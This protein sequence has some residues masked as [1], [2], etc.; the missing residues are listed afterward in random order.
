MTET[1]TNAASPPTG[2][3]TTWSKTLIMSLLAAVA[4]GVV[5]L[6]FLWPVATSS[7]KDLPVGIVGPQI[8]V[9]QVEQN[10]DTNAPGVFDTSTY[11]TR[12]EAI[13]AIRTRDIDGAIV[14][15]RAPE[16]LIASAAGPAV[17]SILKG[18]AGSMQQQMSAQSARPG[19]NPVTTTVT[20]TDVVPLAGDDPNGSGLSA[21]GFPLVLAGLLGGILISLLVAGVTRR[22]VALVV[23]AILGGVSVTLVT[24]TWFG[25]LPG[26]FFL[27]C[28]GISLAVLGT[29]SFVVGMN[30]LIGPPGIAVGAVITMFVGNPLSAATMPVQF[31]ATPWGAIGQFLVP[32]AG[33]TLVRDLSYFPDAD[34]TQPWLVLTAWAVLGI[35]LSALG[36]YRNREV[37]HV[38]SLEEPVTA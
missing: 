10:L 35:A 30:S 37:L 3:V 2:P 1:S 27:L 24:H 38:P 33:A 20:T 28:A 15:G 6:A 7:A 14:A 26:N 31:L 18:V 17:V 32:G 8:A 22:L 25:I 36:H 11:A 34:A 29:A 21:L 13:T 19:V 5:V 12:D 4:I 16:V 23:F 9:A